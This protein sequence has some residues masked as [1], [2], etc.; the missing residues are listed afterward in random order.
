MEREKAIN[1]LQH[2]CWIFST[3]FTF[4]TL[5]LLFGI[6]KNFYPQMPVIKRYDWFAFKTGVL[7]IVRNLNTMKLL[8]TASHVQL[9]QQAQT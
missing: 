9:C 6:D 1:N 3:W 8:G 2:V 4:A 5:D 7:S